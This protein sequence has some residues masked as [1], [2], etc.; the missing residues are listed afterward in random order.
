[1]CYRNSTRCMCGNK[2]GNIFMIWSANVWNSTNL[3]SLIMKSSPVVCVCCIEY[4]KH[5]LSYT[6]FNT[7]VVFQREYGCKY[8]Q[9]KTKYIGLHGYYR[10][11]N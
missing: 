6:P 4:V 11:Y 10:Q 8:K 1:M 3:K 2:Q 7:E 5:A 9:L